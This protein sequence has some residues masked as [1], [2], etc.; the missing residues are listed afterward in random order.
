MS[1]WDGSCCGLSQN[2]N[3]VP[4]YDNGLFFLF[5]LL[6][7]Q[8]RKVQFLDAD[9]RYCPFWLTSKQNIS[10]EF[11]W[12]SCQSRICLVLQTDMILFAHDLSLCLLFSDAYAYNHILKINLNSASVPV[13]VNFPH[14]QVPFKDPAVSTF[15]SPERPSLSK[16]SACPVGTSSISRFSQDPIIKP[17]PCPIR[18]QHNRRNMRPFS[19]SIEVS[20]EIRNLIVGYLSPHQFVTRRKSRS[21]SL[22]LDSKTQISFITAYIT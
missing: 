10:S 13:I 5:L 22:R 2:S 4:E 17:F 21:V 1:A 12:S 14:L 11:A 15:P 7:L 8:T 9:N 6:I 18:K 16:C 20:Q 19:V 3:W